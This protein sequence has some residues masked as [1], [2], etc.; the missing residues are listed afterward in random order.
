MI[1]FNI[2][3]Y[4]NS[5]INQDG[6]Y[7]SKNINEI[8]YP[9]DGNDDCFSIE[10][11][12]F[13]FKHRNNCIISL[14]KKYAND[15]VF[16]D[17]GGGNGFVCKGL[18]NNGVQTCLIEPGIQGC[19]NAKTRDLTNIVCSDLDNAELKSDSISS[20]GLFDVIEHIE[21]DTAFLHKI[22][23]Y[24][25]AGGTV[26]IT[27]PAYNFLWSK[28]DADAG[29]FKRYTLHGLKTILKESGFE[30]VYSTY[31]FSF[32]IL[33]ILFFRTIP[34]LFGL[35]KT[36]IEKHKK[37]HGVN[38]DGFV[39]KLLAKI[40]SFEIKQIEKNRKIPFGGS[41]LVVAKKETK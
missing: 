30:T 19:L 20:A 27:V 13:W 11:N 3:N 37:E 26:F 18:A 33:P 10:D 9:K 5:L 40:L 12:S 22:N 28:E 32:L 2:N 6:I 24:L 7:F 8:S 14:V 16:F 15:D 38:N 17:I 35:A 29:H 41:C 1:P 23:N 25:Q 21:D 36:G 4:T 34:S 31:I 39:S